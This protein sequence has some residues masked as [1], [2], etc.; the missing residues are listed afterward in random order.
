M[1][2]YKS[3]KNNKKDELVNDDSELLFGNDDLIDNKINEDLKE[4]K[5]KLKAEKLSDEFKTNLKAK[6]QEELNKTEKSDNGKIIKFPNVTRKLAGLCACL[7]F[8][9]SSCF[10]FADDIENVILELFGKT[11]KIIANAIEEGNYKEIE[12]DYVEDQG[13]SIKV[14]YVVVKD[15][16]LYIAFDILNEEEFDRVF[17]EDVNIKSQ[18]REYVYT[19]NVTE[20][21]SNLNFEDKRI[22]SKN[23]IMVYKLVKVECELKN[24]KKLNV[25]IKDIYFIKDEKFTNI[26]GNWEFEI[27]I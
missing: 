22:N 23:T 1:K 15:D 19:K 3:I 27:N 8:L 9:F 26:K 14:D 25:E 20:S 13:V 7:V 4:I 5:E 2:E 6:L 17:F 21:N 10:A 16:E 24:V 11:D 12:M 18:D